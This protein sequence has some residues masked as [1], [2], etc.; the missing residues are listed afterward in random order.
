[1]SADYERGIA[2][3][4]FTI[5]EP[6]VTTGSLRI[7]LAAAMDDRRRRIGEHAAAS[8][9]PW[10]V[11]ALGAPPD[12][13]AA[14]LVWQRKAAA[15][16]AYRELSGH[17]HPDDPIGPEPAT[18]SP[19]L[20]AAWTEARAALT[21]DETGDIRHLTDGQL[22]NLRA[23]RPG[24]ARSTLPAVGQLHQARAAARREPGSAA[25]PQRS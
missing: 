19:D 22:L 4:D 18:G 24:D 14:R 16:G 23:A 5:A 17:D 1:M 2:V 10:A 21:L 6:S 25:R 8:S 15:I 11:A 12:D 7:Q 20:R 9:L 3:S 13:P